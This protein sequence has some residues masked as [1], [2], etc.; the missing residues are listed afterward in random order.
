MKQELAETF[1]ADYPKLAND[2]Y[3]GVDD[4]WYDLLRDMF[5]EVQ[6]ELSKYIQEDDT[7]FVQIKEKFGNLRVYMAGD[8]TKEIYD[9]IEKYERLS[10]K[11]CEICGKAGSKTKNRSYVQTLCDSCK[12]KHDTT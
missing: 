10:G 3:I 1:Y 8:T 2:V 9:V 6:L 4:G 5:A 7:Y 12:H 11:V